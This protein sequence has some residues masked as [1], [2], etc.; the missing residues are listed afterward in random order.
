MRVL[1]LVLLLAATP[2]H[3]GILLEARL[4]GTDVRIELG[5]DPGRAVVTVAGEPRL[6]ELNGTVP[7]APPEYRLS[8]WS[9]GPL[10]AGYGT[11][12]NVLM[13]DATICGEV[14]AAP[15]MAAFLQPAVQ[16]IAQLQQEDRR[17]APVA[18]P[19]CG[20]IPFQAFAANGFPLMAGWKD[21]P[22]FVTS[23]L[24]FDH[25]PPPELVPEP[26]P[27]AASAA[28]PAPSPAP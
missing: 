15:W 23:R 28:S 20:A 22:V 27:A 14:L 7:A 9:T 1:V 3:A 12:Y 10:I 2:A 13:L 5:S 24:R 25:Q 6:I 16:A 8:R 4:N 19:D 17:L 21:E 18:R 26:A 11:T